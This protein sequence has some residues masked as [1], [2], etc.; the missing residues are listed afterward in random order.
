[1]ACPLGW[2]M[3]LAYNRCWT[4]RLRHRLLQIEL[5]NG[6]SQ[7]LAKS[8]KASLTVGHGHWEPEIWVEAQSLKP[9]GTCS[10]CSTEPVGT[11]FTYSSEVSLLYCVLWS[12]NLDPRP[13]HTRNSE[14]FWEGPYGI[15]FHLCQHP[16]TPPTPRFFKRQISLR[17]MGFALRP[18]CPSSINELEALGLKRLDTKKL[19]RLGAR[20]EEML[21]SS[22]TPPAGGLFW[23]VWWVEVSAH[24]CYVLFS[25]THNKRTL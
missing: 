9:L 16:P 23:L 7:M 4:N 20:T 5:N 2:P 17:S 11:Y 3:W 25:P 8:I 6:F 18:T 22:S 14:L 10:T 12:T 1:M 19:K 21:P 24:P 13:C 15:I